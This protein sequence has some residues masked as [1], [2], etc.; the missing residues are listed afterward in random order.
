MNSW[1]SREGHTHVN[2]D[3]SFQNISQHLR[4]PYKPFL[5]STFWRVR[6][7]TTMYFPNYKW[8]CDQEHKLEMILSFHGI[9]FNLQAPSLNVSEYGTSSGFSFLV[10]SPRHQESSTS[11]LI[12]HFGEK[13]CPGFYMWIYVAI[14]EEQRVFPLSSEP[15]TF[16]YW[17]PHGP[18]TTSHWLQPREPLLC[19]QYWSCHIYH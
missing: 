2:P 6:Q 8:K 3:Q 15:E 16:P 4:A 10:T 7:I 18:W 13:R 5:L 1:N 9:W 12:V 17:A 11:C 19:A 14:A